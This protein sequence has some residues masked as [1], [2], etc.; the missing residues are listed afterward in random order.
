[1]AD[2]GNLTAKLT[3]DTA[4]FSSGVGEVNSLVGNLASGVGSALGG[5]ASAVTAAVVGAAAAVGSLVKDSVQNFAQYEQL[6][7][8]VE[9]MFKESAGKVQEY[10]DQAYRTAGISSNNY[11]EQVT[12][13]S[14]RL[15]DSLEGDTDKAVQ[16]AD[17]AITDMADNANKLGT[18]VEDIQRAYQGFAK[19]NF[20]MLDNL[21]LGYGG[22]KDEM[23]RLLDK[24]Q[25]ISGIEYKIDNFGDIIQAIHVIQD[26]LGITGTTAEEAEKTIS[27][28]FQSMK[29]AW[30]NVLT[31]ISQGGPKL[32]KTIEE[33]TEAAETFAKNIL[34]VIEK[35]LHGIGDLVRKLAPVIAEALPDFITEI[36]P[37]LIEAVMSI[38][39]ELVKGLPKIVNE[40]SRSAEAIIPQLVEAFISLLDILI[41]DVLPNII[42][43]AITLILELGKALSQNLPKLMTSIVELVLYIVQ[44]ILEN[45]PKIVEIG[46]QIVL[47]IVQGLVDNIDTIIDAFIQIIPLLVETAMELIPKLIELGGKLILAVA[48]GILLAIPKFLG[49]ILQ[50]FGVFGD[51]AKSTKKDVDTTMKDLGRGVESTMTGITSNINTSASEMFSAMSQTGSQ[52]TT[53]ASSMSSSVQSAMVPIYDSMGNLIGEFNATA[54]ATKSSSSTIASESS[55]MRSD[56]NATNKAASSSVESVN[57]AMNKM[58][59]S[60]NSA[61]SALDKINSAIGSLGQVAG[62]A[63]GDLSELSDILGKIAESSGESSGNFTEMAGTFYS[64]GSAA[65]SAASEIG[66]LM[67]E[68]DNLIN[69]YSSAEI[70]LKVSIE[71]D[72][73]GFQVEDQTMIVHVNYD[74][75]G[76]SGGGYGGGHAAG[77]PVSAGTTY[78]VGELG[79]ELITPTRSGYVHTAEETED[80][81]GG[82]GVGDIYITI[83]GDVYD[84]ERSMRAKM[85]S[86]ILSVLE[87][88]VAYG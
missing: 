32:D 43:L 57:A 39:D 45:L 88:Q 37:V 81:L 16:L 38:V 65:S 34:P 85:K 35:A 77:G 62:T 76:Y 75:S 9:T 48:E 29:A 18:N 86:A 12:S 61:S 21:K 25:E 1:M 54:S 50:A 31:A 23:Q 36:V 27:G 63:Q 71:Y 19:D 69:N 11:M 22:T 72:D 51:A 80:I 28:S 13:F 33:F 3:L 40:L 42:D 47:A 70:T 10:A 53:A 6:A 87:E 82:S 84:D 73:P 49:K 66:D 15:I 14:A 2:V 79:P 55:K 17:L 7:G 64:I 58:S 41:N 83:Q 44:V 30:D 68:L 20:T 60:A 56:L 5:V 26:E 46:G 52:L 67:R 24:A 78:L 59:G 4:S 74:D 8:G